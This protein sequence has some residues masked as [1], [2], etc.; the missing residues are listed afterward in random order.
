MFAMIHV[1]WFVL[2]LVAAISLVYSASRHE[3]WRLIWAGAGRLAATILGI[4]VAT[5][6][7]LLF[8]NSRV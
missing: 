2:P 3:D 8:I 7:I 4:L 1:Y 6:L 5:T